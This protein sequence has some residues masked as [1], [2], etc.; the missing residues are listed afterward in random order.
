V[1]PDASH[2]SR[3]WV[4]P[5]SASRVLLLLWLLLF[6]PSALGLFALTFAVAAGLTEVHGNFAD[7]AGLTLG[8]GVVLAILATGHWWSRRSLARQEQRA[9]P[10]WPLK[11]WL[12]LTLVPLVAGVVTKSIRGDDLGTA[13]DALVNITVLAVFAVILWLFAPSSIWRCL[14][15]KA[16]RTVGRWGVVPWLVI[17]LVSVASQR[18]L[19]NTATARVHVD[20]A[21]RY[22]AEAQ[23]RDAGTLDPPVHR[24]E[25]AECSLNRFGERALHHPPNPGLEATS[26]ARDHVEEACMEAKG[27][28]KQ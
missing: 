22:R 11:P 7:A 1:S 25:G 12:V 23:S 26:R 4:R 15:G 20:T 18:G 5:V 10:R 28:R 8:L 3:W 2:G 19:G 21:R 27:Y 24:Q 9:V 13:E 6:V 17:A 16:R 14:A